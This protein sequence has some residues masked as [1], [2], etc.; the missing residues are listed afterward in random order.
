[1]LVKLWMLV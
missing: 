1:M